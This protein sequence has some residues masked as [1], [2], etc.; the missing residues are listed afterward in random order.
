LFWSR[1]LRIAAKCTGVNDLDPSR[2]D[3]F[4]ATE[5]G[6]QTATHEVGT[7]PQIDEKSQQLEQMM[8]R[9]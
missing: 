3:Q 6:P 5:S 7:H 9:V 8:W 4:F 2:A 1:E